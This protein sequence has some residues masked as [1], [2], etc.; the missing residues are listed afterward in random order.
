MGCA[1]SSP[2]QVA[3]PNNQIAEDGPLADAAIAHKFSSMLGVPEP[4]LLEALPGLNR[5]FAKRLQSHKLYKPLDLWALTAFVEAADGTKLGGS[6]LRALPPED[7]VAELDRLKKETR[8]A[9]LSMLRRGSRRRGGWFPALGL[10]LLAVHK[11]LPEE[12][13]APVSSAYDDGCRFFALPDPVPDHPMDKMHDAYAYGRELGGKDMYA[14]VHVMCMG[15]HMHTHA[16]RVHVACTWQ[17]HVHVH[18]HVMSRTVPA[19]LGML[20]SLK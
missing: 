16:T 6:G 4:M 2:A 13:H 1:S 19:R 14:H 9:V 11:H 20:S 17:G 8:E 10:G 3:P 5:C 7:V 18:V 12:E 15:M